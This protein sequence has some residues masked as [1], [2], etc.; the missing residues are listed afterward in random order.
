MVPYTRGPEFS[1]P[2]DDIINET[3]K[4][5]SNGIKEIILLGQNVNAYHG[6]C[7]NGQSRDLAYL[8]NK[9]SEIDDV[10]RIR[11]MTS[12]PIDM[13]DSLINI[14]ASNSKLMPLHLPI[15]SGSNEILKKWI[16]N[17]LLMTI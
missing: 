17:T 3:K 9:I 8:I 12:H 14:H 10:K 15:Q 13:K 11:Y 4:Y 6:I 2:V 1:R 5:T 16:E 7:S